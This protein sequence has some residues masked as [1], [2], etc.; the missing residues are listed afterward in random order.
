M[1][2]SAAQLARAI[3]WTGA[4]A[5]GAWSVDFAPVEAFA[6]V[7]GPHREG[8]DS[9]E[10]TWRLSANDS[11]IHLDAHERSE[12]SP[13]SGSGCE[14]WRF[15]SLLGGEAV[16]FEGDVPPTPVLDELEPSLWVRSN[17]AGLRVLARIVLPRSIDA[18][19]G[20]PIEVLLPGER[21]TRANAWQELR[22]GN[23][24][25]LLSKRS[26]AL[27]AGR[28]DSIDIREAYLDGLALEV[29][30]DGTSTK[31]W[32]DDLSIDGFV[33]LQG[34]ANRVGRRKP[35]RPRES[36]SIDGAP[37]I[38]LDGDVLTA[39][40]RPIFPRIIEHQGEPLE[41]LKR[42][43]FNGVKF[44]RVPSA[45]EFAEARRL[46]LWIVCPPPPE[47]LEG[48]PAPTARVPLRSEDLALILAWFVG[49]EHVAEDA[50]ELG[51]RLRK[52]RRAEGRSRR[53]T[54]G[55]ADSGL[56][57]FS[58]KFDIGLIGRAPLGSSLELADYSNWL[59]DRT[60]LMLPGVPFW[61]KIQT[62]FPASLEW[63]WSNLSDGAAPA[64]TPS[65]EQIGL[66]V[67]LSVGA[68]SRGV[69]FQS[70]GPL[71]DGDT[72]ARFRAIALE[73][74]NALLEAI[75]P[76][77]ATGALGESVSA[78]DPSVTAATLNTDRTRLLLPAWSGAHSQMVP[79][80]AAANGL[81]FIVPG[82]PDSNSAFELTAGA[83]RP[84]RATRVTGGMRVTLDEFDLFAPVLLTQ[85]SRSVAG[86]TRRL[87]SLAERAARLR[88]ELAAAKYQ[89]TREID[90][91]LRGFGRRVP[92]SAGWLAASMAS[93]TK[94]D[95]ALRSGDFHEASLESRRA[96]RPLRMLQRAH[97]DEAQKG[98]TSL[99]EN[100]LAVSF[101][102]LPESW[103]LRAR[104][105]TSSTSAR[106][107]FV[108][109]ARANEL[110]G[111]EMEDLDA[112]V[113]AGWQNHERPL[114]G[115][116][117]TIGLSPAGPKRGR[118]S[119][120]LAAWSV[121]PALVASA[122]ETAPVWITTPPLATRPGEWLRIHGWARLKGPIQASQDGLLIV[123]SMS[124]WPLAT[125]ITKPGDWSEFS[126][127]RAADESGQT[128]ITIAL[129]G[130]G[131]AF[132]DDLVIERLDDTA[133]VEN[134]G[135][136]ESGARG[137]FPA[138]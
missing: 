78:S 138:R 12:R 15:Q 110:N 127:L 129:T 30:G 115:V 24:P 64:P 107:G 68:G 22:F 84:A 8:F 16:T 82:A 3:L 108:P 59:R 21:T 73:L 80:Q 35:A 133:P 51:Q 67:A 75:E 57:T 121:D 9:P 18:A 134:P 37:P 72:G 33:G 120:R 89:S 47:W 48:G 95:A 42:L 131:E 128:T 94:A 74:Q 14:Y 54:V 55:G 98:A 100:P 118:R 70:R 13:R 40:G 102:T 113:A 58:R 34:G 1:R 2:L 99:V 81:T 4:W 76:W 5:L 38:V 66:L 90:S 65:A 69:I 135:R 19:T 117:A 63:Q 116:S 91:R 86:L 124:G 137:E 31:V 96:M 119:L 10:T 93:L 28:E 32:I 62:Q 132:V 101:A 17:R 109:R 71:D 114:P 29:P 130:L 88:Q 97:W 61:T 77:A 45:D 136:F 6:Q 11:D 25:T 126:L 41:F 53:P 83:L 27:R 49:D 79:A 106:P 52:L 111:G 46:G 104:W 43:G 36:A 60:R 56:A 20:E 26:L 87:G 105:T 123:D 39:Q 103:R 112:M 50:Q 125:R 23:L 85:D 44:P 92:N 122:L 7:A